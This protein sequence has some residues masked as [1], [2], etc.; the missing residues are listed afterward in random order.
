MLEYR[1]TEGQVCRYGLQMRITV[2]IER[3]EEE[4]AVSQVAE[5]AGRIVLTTESIDEGGAVLAVRA[6]QLEGEIPSKGF[7]DEAAVGDPLAAL[8]E[9]IRVGP[10]G[11][12]DTEVDSM[13][14]ATEGTLDTL[15][16]PLPEGSVKPG[17]V[18]TRSS[19]D[20][21]DEDPLIVHAR[22][23][24]LEPGDDGVVR[25]VV[26]T[27]S[28]HAWSAGQGMEGVQVQG[29]VRRMA[30]VSFRQPDGWAQRADSRVESTLRIAGDA[31]QGARSIITVVEML[32]M[33][34]S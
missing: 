10:R 27:F 3:T 8:P 16:P 11:E 33:A 23:I 19:S 22:F 9:R 18:W 17:D 6:E 21:S 12:S 14:E 28:G 20:E 2:Q 31:E 15:F 1:F 30:E 34:E 32:L 24:G 26:G 5:V 4:G 25:P 13:R 29:E 7:F